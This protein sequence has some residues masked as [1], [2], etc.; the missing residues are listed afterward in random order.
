MRKIVREETFGMKMDHTEM[1]MLEEL[2]RKQ[3]MTKSAYVRYV[4]M[5][6]AM[7]GHVAV[8]SGWKGEK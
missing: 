3:G 1:M 2:S 4:I 6:L 7:Y 8:D 5:Q